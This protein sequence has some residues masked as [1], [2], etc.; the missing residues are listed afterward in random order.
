MA[1]LQIEP[2]QQQVQSMEVQETSIPDSSSYSDT[3]NNIQQQQQQ[4]Q[5]QSVVLQDRKLDM[6]NLSTYKVRDLKEQLD[7]WDSVIEKSKQG[8]HKQPFLKDYCAVKDQLE[9]SSTQASQFV[10]LLQEKTGGIDDVL[11]CNIIDALSDLN[12]EAKFGL[13]TFVSCSAYLYNE[14]EKELTDLR[15]GYDDL[16]RKHEE[17]ETLQQKSKQ[18]QEQRQQQHQPFSFSTNKRNN[19]NE[20]SFNNDSQ[21]Q[22]PKV[23]DEWSFLGGNNGNNPLATKRVV[24]IHASQMYAYDIN[25]QFSDIQKNGGTRADAVNEFFNLFQSK[26]NKC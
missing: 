6:K 8:L 1:D 24:D 25:K 4:Q 17:M 26:V 23:K 14:K 18:E 10:E 5:N 16:K 20:K 7:F 11:K 15:K 9:Q 2:L 3:N 12:S 21:Q 19:A 13:A 22:P